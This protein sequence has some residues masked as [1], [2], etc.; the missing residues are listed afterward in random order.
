MYKKIPLP[1]NVHFRK[2]RYCSTVER[3]GKRKTTTNQKSFHALIVLGTGTINI[4][5]YYRYSLSRE[6]LLPVPVFRTRVHSQRVQ[7]TD[8]FT[9]LQ[10]QVFTI[11]KI[12]CN[13]R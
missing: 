7:S 11:T 4:V 12:R 8:D 13:S 5:L 3:R 6:S 2:C 10:N 9:I 1:T